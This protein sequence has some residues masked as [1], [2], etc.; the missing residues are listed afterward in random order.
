MI[1]YNELRKQYD[2]KHRELMDNIVS[3]L[4]AYY[5]VD[6]KNVSLY[7][8]HY[9]PSYEIEEVESDIE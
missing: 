9:S 4:A 8:L 6:K 7:W 1:E 3:E 5:K 2:N